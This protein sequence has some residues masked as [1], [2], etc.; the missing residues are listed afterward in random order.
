MVRGDVKDQDNESVAGIERTFT[1]DE[2]GVWNVKHDYFMFND[3]RDKGTGF[4]K[5]FL[6]QS[7][8]WY[9]A[10]GFGSISLYTAAEGAVHWARQGFDFDEKYLENNLTTLARNFPTDNP[11]FTD[12]M[13][14]ATNGYNPSN[15]SFDSVKPMT[16]DRFPTPAEFALIG[17]TKGATDWMGGNSMYGVRMDY[18]KTLTA[19]GRN[20]ISGGGVNNITGYYE[21]AGSENPVDRDGDGLVF[22]GT[23]R[24]K[25][26]PKKT[27]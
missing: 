6:Q 20:L 1:R 21:T 9:T 11:K 13:Q 26:V 10:R 22:D 17:Y 14:R 5:V 3:D 4:G 16:T 7:E 8:D 25:P 19:E 15:G 27:K 12:L 23:A 2:N 24:E 18:K